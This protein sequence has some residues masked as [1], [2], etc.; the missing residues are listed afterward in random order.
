MHYC[1]DSIV[2]SLNGLSN[3]LHLQ[4]S[5]P[6]TF[7]FECYLQELYSLFDPAHGAQKLEQQNMSPEEIDE[8]EQTF[9]KYLFQVI[10]LLDYFI[11]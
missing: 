8:L 2:I 5:L 4:S 6:L 9:L 7:E 1:E 3:F 10:W 11:L